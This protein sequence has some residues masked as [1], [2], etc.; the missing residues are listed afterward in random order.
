MEQNKKDKYTSIKSQLT[1]DKGTKTN[2]INSLFNK[3]NNYI[4]TCQNKK[5]ESRWRPHTQNKLTQNGS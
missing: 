5:H 3:W 4:S 2:E 1:L